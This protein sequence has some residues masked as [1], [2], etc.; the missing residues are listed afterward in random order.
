[1]GARCVTHTQQ[2]RQMCHERSAGCG[3]A[4][5]WL[6]TLWL[7][8]AALAVGLC[9][10]VRCANADV[11]RWF[12]YLYV[13]SNSGDSSGG[14]A[15]IC[16]VDR[17]YHFQQDAAQT[18]RLH[19][20]AAVEFD[21]RYRMLGNRTIHATR[22]EVSPDGYE[23]LRSAFQA[24][25]QIQDRQYNHLESL[26]R[27]RQLLELIVERSGGAA[28]EAS[29]APAVRVPGSAYFVGDARDGAAPL[30]G[31]EAGVQRSATIECLAGRVRAVYGDE[32]IERRAATLRAAITE[33]APEPAVDPLPE[34]DRLPV[35]PAGFAT[36]HREL[37]AGWLALAVL[38]AAPPLRAGS[39][40]A[41]AGPD[42]VLQPAEIDVLRAYDRQL[43]EALVQLVASERP[44]W[45]YPLLVGMARLLAIETSIESGHMVVLDDF[46]ENATVIAPD[47]VAR[48]AATLA[49]VRAERQSDFL[50]AWQAFFES[51]S[52]E[53]GQFS[54]LETTA[55][56][57]IDIDAA[58]QQHAPLRVYTGD[59]VP[60]RSALRSDWP[61]PELSDAPY[62]RAVAQ[63]R[64]NAYRAALAGLYHYDLVSHNCVTE[65]FRTIEAALAPTAAGAAPNPGAVR[66]ASTA[67]LG[68][69]VDW[70]HTLNFIPFLSAWAV[71]G[72]YRVEERVERPSA[73][74]MKLEQMYQ[75]ENALRVDLRESNVLTA[76]SYEHSDDEPIFLFFTD[77]VLL[78]R[79]LYGIANLAVGVGGTLAGLAWLPVDHGAILRAGL[80]GALFSLPEIAFINIRKGSFAFAPRRWLD[81]GGT[82]LSESRGSP[83]Q[84]GE[85]QGQLVANR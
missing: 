66:A 7:A 13:E 52:R 16:F 44:D 24:R 18:I 20:N 72:A 81:D 60:T 3:R 38:R 51:P 45:G 73:R 67:A 59:V 63:R 56:L 39:F 4:A 17:C 37:L 14:H 55:N 79:P 27:D 76:Q 65:I 61:L 6:A 10:L 33:L 43:A 57:L 49:Q 9:A 25:L 47:A 2:D 69:Y 83:Q 82:N 12:D 42:F 53:E 15:A 68:G 34:A 8:T 80:N 41:P 1:M 46:G 62:Q 36:R 11:P 19:R 84:G 29:G 77:D 70:R 48:H 31:G 21:Y 40:H 58:L 35:L 50:A 78:R 54:E 26:G 64:E 71:N 23:R 74:S 85:N 5:R 75:H 32:F 28:G 30:W 22:V